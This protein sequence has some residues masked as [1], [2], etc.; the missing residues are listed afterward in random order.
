MQSP[1]FLPLL[2]SSKSSS[3]NKSSRISC[4]LSSWISPCNST[5]FCFKLLSNSAIFFRFL[6]SWICF[7]FLRFLFFSFSSSNF[8]SFSAFN[9][10]LILSSNSAS[11]FLTPLSIAACSWLSFFS[12]SFLCFSSSLLAADFSPSDLASLICFSLDLSSFSNFFT[13]SLLFFWLFFFNLFF[14]WF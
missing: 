11:L 13:S 1:P 6:S 10:F 14:V 3:G 8:S 12:N 2:I 7:S 9:L 5:L 4:N